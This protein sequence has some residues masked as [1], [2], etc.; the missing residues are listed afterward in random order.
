MYH[1]KITI[2]IF[3]Y[4]REEH[5][6]QM[7]KKRIVAP[8]QI[9]NTLNNS[10]ITIKKPFPLEILMRVFL[11]FFVSNTYKYR[12]HTRKKL[13]FK[14]NDSHYIRT[15]IHI[16]ILSPIMYDG[17]LYNK[18]NA[19]QRRDAEYIL[20]K[21]YPMFCNRSRPNDV[22]LDVGSA[23]GNVTVDILYP[24]LPIDIFSLTA[25]DVSENMVNYARRKYQQFS[26][27]S[28]RVLDIAA[29]KMPDDFYQRFNQI[30]SFYCLHW[31]QD[32]R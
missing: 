17:E 30:Y 28:F 9:T 16:T 15:Y 13:T 12:S 18:S 5:R 4:N 21:Y 22:I 2:P 11:V 14:S 27:I 29:L 25:V 19:L 23:S 7:I 31:V 3:G 10:M 20:D 26:K 24:R 32:Q 8:Q 6:G 1:L